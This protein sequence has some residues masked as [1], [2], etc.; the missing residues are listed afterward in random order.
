MRITEL[1]RKLFKNIPPNC[2][3]PAEG[4]VT[5]HSYMAKHIA[6]GWDLIRISG[7]FEDIVDVHM[8]AYEQTGLPQEEGIFR[9][10][11]PD[12]TV[13]N[14]TVE[15]EVCLRDDF[16]LKG[17]FQPVD[18]LW[19]AAR[20]DLKEMARF[21]PCLRSS[22]GQLEANED[23]VRDTVGGTFLSM[24]GKLG[25]AALC[26]LAAF[27]LYRLIGPSASWSRDAAFPFSLLLGAI[28]LVGW[29][30]MIG[31]GIAAAVF[32]WESLCRL[33]KLPKLIFSVGK[34]RKRREAYWQAYRDVLRSLRLRQ[35][36]YQH[37][38]GEENKTFR[39]MQR[40]LEKMV[41][42]YSKEMKW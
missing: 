23:A 1:D 31:G 9:F 7:R 25:L 20:N 38:T 19:G 17:Y 21:L 32:L 15:G 5:F 40:E 3:A 11:D 12:A 26:A 2:P 35:L 39:D 41:A 30:G 22:V 10:P 16:Y 33:A 13:V 24:L 14:L 6:K 42:P 8:H 34:D 18:R 29:A 27:G 37:L 36:L 28:P 4:Q